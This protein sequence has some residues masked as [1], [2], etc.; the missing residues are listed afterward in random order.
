MSQEQSTKGQ[1]AE[2][3]TQDTKAFV[4]RVRNVSTYG[5]LLGPELSKRLGLVRAPWEG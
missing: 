4:H 5:T 2:D 3:R 1:Q